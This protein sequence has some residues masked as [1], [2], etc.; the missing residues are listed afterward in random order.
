MGAA[1]DQMGPAAHI[2]PP[3]LTHLGVVQD[4]AAVSQTEHEGVHGRTEQF[5]DAL[6]VLHPLDGWLVH[7]DEGVTSVVVEREAGGRRG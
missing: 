5:I 6:F 7:V 2:M 4:R 3:E 1:E